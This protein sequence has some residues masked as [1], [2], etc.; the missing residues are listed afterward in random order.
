MA[1]RCIFTPV[2]K[3]TG[4]RAQFFITQADREKFNAMPPGNSRSHVKVT[5]IDSGTVLIARRAPCNA[6]CYCDATYL[7][8]PE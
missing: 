6:S 4:E 3:K 1:D 8:L 2:H 5:D 7:P